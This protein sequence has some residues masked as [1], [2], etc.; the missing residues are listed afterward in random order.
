MKTIIYTVATVTAFFGITTACLGQQAADNKTAAPGPHPSD[1]AAV[2]ATTKQAYLGAGVESMHPSLVGQLAH[3]LGQGR[4]VTV[5][6]L[7]KGSPADA[8]G[9]QVNDVVV[10]YDDQH[11]YSPEQLVKFVQSDKPGREVALGIV[12]GGDKKTI[13]VTLGEHE[14]AQSARRNRMFSWGDT[15]RPLRTG[16]RGDRANQWTSFESMT[17]TQLDDHHFKAEIRY[18][19]DKGK[20]ESHAFDGTRD[21]IRKDI[22]SQRDLPA[23]ER[24]HLLRAIDMANRPSEFEYPGVFF[25]PDQGIFWDLDQDFRQP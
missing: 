12:R 25:L 11:I 3:L 23:S 8:A 5:T 17:L 24:H 1:Q 2:A 13:K 16:E 7:L 22:E 14:L 19:D 4:D 21:E 20:L 6:E 10:S 15:A 18:R 9:L